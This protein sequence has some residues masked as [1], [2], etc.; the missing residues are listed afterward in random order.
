MWG[1]LT[2][3]VQ[4]GDE[5]APLLQVLGPQS[6]QRDQ[7]QRLLLEAGGI[8]NIDITFKLHQFSFILHVF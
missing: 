6:I 5:R 3:L 1:T 4:D 8:R 2:E 7:Q